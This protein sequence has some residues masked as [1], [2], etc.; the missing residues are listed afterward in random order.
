MMID[1]IR[2]L[3]VL[4]SHVALQRIFQEINYRHGTES[5][6]Q[7]ISILHIQFEQLSIQVEQLTK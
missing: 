2:F 4:L 3:Y 1:A 7:Q 6:L 5:T